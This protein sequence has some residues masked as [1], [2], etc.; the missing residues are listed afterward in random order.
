MIAPLRQ[1]TAK[2]SEN[3]EIQRTTKHMQVSLWDNKV[4]LTKH[5]CHI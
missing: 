5:L 2:K 4:G 1:K 3:N